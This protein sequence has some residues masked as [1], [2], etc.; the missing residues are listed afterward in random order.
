MTTKRHN[1]HHH[2]AGTGAVKTV[3]ASQQHHAKTLLQLVAMKNASLQ[4]VVGLIQMLA[5]SEPHRDVVELTKD[6]MTEFEAADEIVGEA[7]Q[8][9]DAES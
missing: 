1:K 3:S 6:L 2:A 5:R 7:L 4:L 9:M 8:F